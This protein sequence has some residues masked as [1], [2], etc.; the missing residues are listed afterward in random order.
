MTQP[1]KVIHQSYGKSNVR[2]SRIERHGSRH[3]FIE[4]SI[5]I[6]LRGKRFDASYS[7]ADNSLVVATDTMKNTVYALAGRHGIGSIESFS[8]QLGRHFL[9]TYRH[10]DEV[11]IRS[12][13]KPWAR[14]E[15]SGQQHDHAFLGGSSERFTC[16]LSAT[17]GK[18][19]SMT[20]G[21]EGLQVLKTTGSSFEHFLRDEFTT[22]PEANDRIFATSISAHWH[23][24][25]LSAD[26]TAAR[27]AIRA[28]LLDVFANKFSKSVQ[29][30]LYEMAGAALAA[31]PL[32]DEITIM[33]PNQHHLLA[34]LAPF[35]LQ[36]PN[37]V[38]VPTSEPFGNI[39]ATI[40]RDQPKVK[41]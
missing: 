35:G 22:L 28:A 41:S 1:P 30:T 34:N 29:H 9:E 32:I 5:D 20:C 2:L 27:T 37:E 18:P 24:V 15:F 4:L 36:N 14:M 39:S 11:G 10:V 16:E 13:E 12:V 8:Q 26:W 40:A 3:T 6:Q 23:C 21:L 19:A 38:F 7:A 31:C 33:M 17:R 25:D